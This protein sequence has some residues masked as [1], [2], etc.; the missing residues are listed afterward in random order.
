MSHALVPFMIVKPPPPVLAA[1]AVFPDQVQFDCPK[2][3]VTHCLTRGLDFH[4]GRDGVWRCEEPGGFECDCGALIQC[5]FVVS[6]SP[7]PEPPET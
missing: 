4:E 3:D 5:D 1:V 6:R 7:P 2:C